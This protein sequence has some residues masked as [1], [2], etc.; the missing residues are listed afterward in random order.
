M[1]R[2]LI[3]AGK[4]EL[5]LAICNNCHLNKVELM[6]NW[7]L[8]ELRIGGSEC[9]QSTRERVAQYY[10]VLLILCSTKL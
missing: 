6:Y 4:F 9:M 5:A 8:S 10:Q 1:L 2:S 3:N 7:S